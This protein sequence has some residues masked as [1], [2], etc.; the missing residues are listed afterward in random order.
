MR[1]RQLAFLQEPFISLGHL[2]MLQ[3]K[4]GNPISLQCLGRACLCAAR[5]C[6]GRDHDGV[7]SKAIDQT[8][9]AH[10]RAN[11]ESSIGTVRR[12]EAQVTATQRFFLDLDLLL[13][14]ICQHT[15]SGSPL[16]WAGQRVF[17]TCREESGSLLLV[18]H[19][20]SQSRKGYRGI[21]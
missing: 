16:L 21:G 9:A 2:F 8:I 12:D 19:E 1:E 20:R 17:V 18:P 5:L 14:A 15:D 4:N 11:G 13:Q 6:I 10:R 3:H 7:I